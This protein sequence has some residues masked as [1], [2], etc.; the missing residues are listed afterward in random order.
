MTSFLSPQGW[1][2]TGKCILVS[3]LVTLPRSRPVRHLPPREYGV[4]RGRPLST[5][6]LPPEYGVPWGGPLSTTVLRC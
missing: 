5:M 2:K 4:P 3:I 1:R 6:C